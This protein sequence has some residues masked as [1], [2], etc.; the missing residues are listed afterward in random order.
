MEL[1]RGMRLT[2]WGGGSMISG[3]G[4]PAMRILMGLL[5]VGWM[6]PV[7]VRA[8]QSGSGQPL[9]Q[10]FAVTNAFKGKPAM[11]N[12]SSHPQANKYRT[13][14]SLQA[15]NKPDFASHYKI[16]IWGCG[17]ACAAFTIIDSESGR[18]YFP[19]ELPFFT[20]TGWEGDDFGLKFRIDSRLLV[21]HGSPQEESKVG[22]FYYV[23]QTNT[24][25][26]IR[27]E[28]KK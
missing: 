23:W 9:Y 27:S 6:L 8:E 16:A 15:A 17:S 3:M 10:N 18:V 4:K 22:T 7:G 12:F 5:A 11:V 2:R 24:L 25:R 21:L 20:W 14:L 19:P 1:W 26:L 13:E 28:L